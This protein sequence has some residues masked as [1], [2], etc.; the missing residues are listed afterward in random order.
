V[1]AS[2]RDVALLDA[3]AV[4]LEPAPAQPTAVGLF[5]LRVAVAEHFGLV[6]ERADPPPQPSVTR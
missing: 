1:T 6:A 3:L 5:R 2:R 4:A